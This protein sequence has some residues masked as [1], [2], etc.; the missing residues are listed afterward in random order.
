MN[1]I[2]AQL[3]DNEERRAEAVERTGL[4]DSNQ[5]SLFNI[6]CELAKDITGYDA[7]L[8]QL[9]DSKER[10]YLA[11]SWSKE[12]KIKN[13]NTRRPKDG[14]VCSHV[15]LDTKPLLAFDVTKHEITKTHSNEKGVKSYI[16]FPIIDKNNYALGMVCMMTFSKIKELS[17]DKIDLVEKLIKKA[18]HQID[19]MSDQKQLTSDRLINAVDT[20]SQETSIKDMIIFKNFIHACNGMYISKDFEEILIEN[21]LCRINSKSRLELTDKGKKIQDKMG[22]HTKIM[23]NITLE[24]K[25]ANDLI[26]G[27]LDEL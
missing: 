6:Y 8:F 10:C 19:I 1:F 17:Q 24:G 20:F 14:S 18:A 26:E 9:F 25:Q 22:L 27:M 13:L 21:N 15:L 2:S 4:I 5:A 11:E 23:N 3:P 16:G 7:G 12:E